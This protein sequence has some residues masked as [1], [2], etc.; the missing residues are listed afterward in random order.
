MA[1]RG[2]SNLCNNHWLRRKFSLFKSTLIFYAIVLQGSLSKTE[3][4][5]K[6]IDMGRSHP[7]FKGAKP[8][9]T[10]DCNALV[11]KHYPEAN[12][13]TWQLLTGLFRLEL[14]LEAAQRGTLSPVT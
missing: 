7:L 5:G 4:N 10:G 14:N 3:D 2:R 6:F 13:F 12:Y 9:F 1:R 8:I 11:D